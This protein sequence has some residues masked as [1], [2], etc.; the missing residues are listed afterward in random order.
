M[1]DRRKS[2]FFL[3]LTAFLWSLGGILI[4]LVDWNAMAIA[5][6]RSAIAAVC[7]LLLW[8]KFRIR[9][10]L[11]HSPAAIALSRTTLRPVSLKSHSAGLA[12]SVHVVP[13]S[14]DK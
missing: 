12:S 10:T 11:T 6:A 9:W 3:L 1:T 14:V 4:K 7:Q 13:L 2:I 5:G 8:R